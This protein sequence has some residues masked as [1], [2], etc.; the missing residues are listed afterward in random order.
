MIRPQRIELMPTSL[1]CNNCGHQFRGSVPHVAVTSNERGL[2][3][4]QVLS[5]SGVVCPVCRSHW[6]G[7]GQ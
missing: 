4:W 6:I 7:Q 2:L 1:R 3:G 5:C